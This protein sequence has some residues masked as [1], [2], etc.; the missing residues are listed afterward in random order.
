MGAKH[1]LPRFNTF[2]GAAPDIG[3][4]TL[5]VHSTN[6]YGMGTDQVAR[7]GTVYA[8]T[9]DFST[10]MTSPYF[11]P[12]SANFISYEGTENEHETTMTIT[13]PTAD[14]TI[15]FPD[16][17]GTVAFTNQVLSFDGSTSNGICTYKDSDEISVESTLTYNGELLNHYLTPSNGFTAFVS[18]YIPATGWASGSNDATGQTVLFV[19][20][21]NTASG[22]TNS[23]KGL[24]LIITDTATHVG[25]TSYIG[26]K[27]LIDFVNTNGTQEVKGIENTI[28]DCDTASLYGIWQQVE[29]GGTDLYFESSDTTTNDYFSIATGA[30]GAT[31]ITTVDGGGAGA[32]LTFTIDGNITLSTPDE[33]YSTSIDRRKLTVTS[34]TDD[35]HNGD[36]VY[37]GGGSTTKG[38]I[39]YLK[40]DG[41][42]ASAQANAENTSTSL[43][44]IALGTDPDTDG[45]LLRGMY[46]L[47][48]DVANNQGV[49]LYLS[50]GT[51]GQATVTAPSS[52][53]DVVRVIGYNMGDDDQIWFCP[54]NT[55]V[56]VT[57]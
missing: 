2:S 52:N 28:T 5:M 16:A 24:Y 23:Y 9:G 15:T 47:D 30:S 41:E 48:H 53:N 40:T 45:M 42:W 35:D 19:N 13:D 38:D 46:T 56:V 22:E 36:V 27:N 4:N 34:S 37:F 21:R 8:A 44:A 31:T 17:S 57:A 26:L 1:L 14:R 25:T 32:N 55:W 33:H 7:W 3:S 50:D 39:C 10:K 43:L 29:D 6:Q 51:A 49:P 20:G 11:A 18:T 54:D 12:T